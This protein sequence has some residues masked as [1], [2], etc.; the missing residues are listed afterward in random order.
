MAFKLSTGLRNALMGERDTIVGTDLKITGA[1]TITSTAGALLTTGFRPGDI[2]LLSGWP[3][4]GN[5][6]G[7]YTLG[8]VAAGTMAVSGT[9]L[10]I[11][12]GDTDSTITAV[13]KG[14]KDIF[15]NCVIRVY[16][17]TEPTDADADEG[18]GTL[19]L[20]ITK[21][22]AVLTPGAAANGLN[23]AAIVAGV[24][25]KNTDVW[26][27]AGLA[28]GTAAWYRL[29]DNGRITGTSETAKRCQGTIS[30]SGTTFIL[31]STSIKLGA[32]TTLDTA[33]FTMPA[34]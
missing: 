23:F 7:I 24:L 26:S 25:S 16:S 1:T 19:L 12:D 32:T 31:S 17:G 11:E 8:T 20:E 21:D 10:S 27:D 18:S 14:F 3:I 34:S 2:I 4:A 22:S 6:T 9:A 29:Y 5:N 15:K 28:N 30:T 13:S 33:D